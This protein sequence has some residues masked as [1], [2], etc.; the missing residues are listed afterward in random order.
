MWK[1]GAQYKLSDAPV[2]VYRGISPI[3]N[4]P[5]PGPYSR[6]KPWALLWSSGGEV[7]SY[8]RGIPVGRAAVRVHGEPA[9]AENHGIYLRILKYTR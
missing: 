4:S 8:E 2:L 6:T 5:P 7:V 1:A 9:R 3:R